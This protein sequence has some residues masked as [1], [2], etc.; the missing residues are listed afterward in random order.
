MR[1][2]TAA[3]CLVALTASCH[4]KKTDAERAAEERAAAHKRLESSLTLVPYRSLKTVVRASRMQPPPPDLQ[5]LIAIYAGM[6]PAAAVVPANAVDDAKQIAALA[7]G[8]YRARATLRTIDEDTFPTLWQVFVL[9]PAPLAWY[10]AR[11]EHL[12]LAAAAWLFEVTLDKDPAADVLFYELDRA[13]SEEAWPPAMRTGAQGARGVAYMNAGYH[14]A[15]EEEL[16]GYLGEV[17]RSTDPLRP[18]MKA[19]GHLARAWNRFALDRDEPAN[20]DL[21]AALHE[22]DALGVDNEL[23]DWAWALVHCR[24]GRYPEAA[25]RLEKLAHSPYLDDKERA[26]VLAFAG[27]LEKKKGR[28]LF[29]KQ[30]AQVILI[31]AA[32]A[33]AGGLE[34]V[35]CRIFG[36][37]TGHQIYAPLAYLHHLNAAVADAGGEVKDAGKHGLDAIKAKLGVK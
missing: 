24:R 31:R 28:V 30:R 14:Y 25:K 7:V 21:E 4:H 19:G 23:T 37:E 8:L 33:R 16:T 17:D 1:A 26:E 12:A 2:L 15:A 5:K 29:G 18:W 34:K 22:L 13:P 35:L 20:D 11:V 27:S 9:T 32:V 3:F 10:S 6:R 36:D